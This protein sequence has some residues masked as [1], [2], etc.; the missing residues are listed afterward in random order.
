AVEKVGWRRPARGTD[1]GASPVSAS[2]LG[3]RLRALRAR[4]AHDSSRPGRAWRGDSIKRLMESIKRLMEFGG[5]PTD[6]G[7]PPHAGRGAGRSTRRFW[8]SLGT[9]RAGERDWGGAARARPPRA[10]LGV[11]GSRAA[12]RLR[13]SAPWNGT[14]GYAGLGRRSSPRQVEEVA[15]R[16]G[17]G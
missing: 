6:K 3:I 17:G 4:I 15:P 14:R 12:A 13:G 7:L 8:L 16:R 11:S 9:H 5:G 1:R 10:S 2:S